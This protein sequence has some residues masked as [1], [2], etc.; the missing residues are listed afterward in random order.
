MTESTIHR[1]PLGGARIGATVANSAT[2]GLGLIASLFALPA[3]V[4]AALRQNDPLIV[5]GFTVYGVSLVILF[6]A[7]T[8]YHSLPNSPATRLLR[9]LD[10][11]AIYVLIAGSYT[12]FAV[13]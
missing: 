7:S 5:A 8:I 3:L 9:V 1:S 12:P 4:F 13:S 10:P 2:H 6:A 11:S